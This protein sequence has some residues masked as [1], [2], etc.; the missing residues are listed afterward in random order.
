MIEGYLDACTA[1]G[2]FE[3]WARFERRREACIISIR[4]EGE[5]VGRA[6]ADEY[7]AD[8]LAAKI[9]HG[10]YGFRARLRRPLEPGRHVFTLVEERTGM[11]VWNQ[12]EFPLEVPPVTRSREPITSP[13]CTGQ[14]CSAT[15]RA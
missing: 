8:L 6:V 4:L 13:S 5:E 15:R 1:D 14:G 9:G 2:F 12:L 11:P 3:G 7:R 10:H